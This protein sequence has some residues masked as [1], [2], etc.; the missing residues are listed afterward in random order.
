MLLLECAITKYVLHV[1]S[2]QGR[3]AF[4]ATTEQQDCTLCTSV[5]EREQS[6]TQTYTHTMH[7]KAL[8]LPRPSAH[9]LSSLAA[10]P[11]LF[12]VTYL[13]TLHLNQ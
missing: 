5:D 1:Q 4:S 13:H 8:F 6:H 11:K 12:S 10:P 2:G 7:I 3:L 9:T